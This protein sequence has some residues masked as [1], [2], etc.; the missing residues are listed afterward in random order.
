DPQSREIV[1]AELDK[2]YLGSIIKKIRSVRS[3]FGTSYWDVDT[4]RGRRE[5]VVQ[6]VH[7]NVIWLGERRLLL[8]DVDGNRFEIPDYL[9][10]DKKSISF[11]EEMLF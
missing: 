7:D 9:R 4:D 2:R 11:L 10:L 8:V 1:Q 5:F 6:G 3:D